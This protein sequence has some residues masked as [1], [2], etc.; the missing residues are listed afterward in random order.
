MSVY[1]KSMSTLNVEIENEKKKLSLAL[2]QKMIIKVKILE[3][4]AQVKVTMVPQDRLV[5][6]CPSRIEIT[7]I[8]ASINTETFTTRERSKSKGKRGAPTKL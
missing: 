4:K 1:D 8:M 2:Y 7:S 5:E 3:V 6:I